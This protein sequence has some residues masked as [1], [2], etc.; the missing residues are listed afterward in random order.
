MRNK[1][2]LAPLGEIDFGLTNKLASGLASLLGL[3]VEILHPLEIPQEAYNSQRGQYYTTVILNKLQLLKADEKERILGIID[4]DLYTPAHTY[5]FGDADPLSK[6]AV[7]S[8]CRLRNEFSGFPENEELFFGRVLK[9]SAYQTGR[10]LSLESCPNPKC[11]MHTSLQAIDS[12]LK[13]AK[14]CDNCQRKVL[15]T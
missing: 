3:T 6:V 15:I 9:E 11:V 7:L 8:L 4:E 10:T 1:I 2:I 12:D 5:L 14:F 13:L